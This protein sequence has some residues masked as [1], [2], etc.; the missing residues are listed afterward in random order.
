[1]RNHRQPRNHLLLH[2]SLHARPILVPSLIRICA[3]R[4]EASRFEELEEVL[5]DRIE[6]GDECTA[7]D[8][9]AKLD[10]SGCGV[11]MHSVINKVRGKANQD[12][13]SSRCHSDNEESG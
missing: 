7:L 10:E 6:V 3:R 13:I 8:A 9:F 2:I 5:D 1:M 4:R 12:G 11:D